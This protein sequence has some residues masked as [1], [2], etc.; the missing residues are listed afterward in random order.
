MQGKTFGSTYSKF[1]DAIYYDKDYKKECDWI[2]NVLEK[3]RIKG[4]KILDLGCGSGNHAIELAKRGYEVVGVDKSHYM[5][6]RATEK[7]KNQNLKIDFIEKDIRNFDLG[8]KFDVVISMFSVI[9]YITENRDLLSTFSNVKKHLK[10][11]G[12]FIFDAWFG[13]AILHQKPEPKIKE[14]KISNLEKIIRLTFPELNIL[15]HTV[16]ITYKLF[17][18]SESSFE[19]FE[20]VH[21]IRYF[22]PKE[23]EFFLTTAGFEKVHLFPFL[24]LEGKPSIDDRDFSCISL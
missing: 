12:I 1:Y 4:R 23:I 24:K 9:S 18:I 14:I 2:E 8:V 17:Y 11:G 5:I 22:F 13:P 20:E 16:D 21:K 7:V 15:D 6:E 19:E 10:D 3:F